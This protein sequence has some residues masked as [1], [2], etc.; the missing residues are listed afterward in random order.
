[1]PLKFRPMAVDHAV[2]LA[3]FRGDDRPNSG[4]TID[5][6]LGGQ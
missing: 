4:V 5:H 1:V 6:F 2:S 3:K